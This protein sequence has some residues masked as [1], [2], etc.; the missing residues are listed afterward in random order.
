MKSW[1]SNFSVH[2]IIHALLLCASVSA[3]AALPRGHVFFQSDFEG[4]DDLNP[5]SGRKQVETG[6]QSA[7]SLCVENRGAS[8][9]G[10][11]ASLTLPAE[12]M[13]GHVVQVSA[14]VKAQDVSAKPNPWNG[15]KLMLVIQ[16]PEGPE[17][18]QAPLGVGSFDWQQAVYQ[19]RIPTNATKITL[20]A[21]MEQVTGKV[22]FDDVK[23]SVYRAMRTDVPAP[24]AGPMHKGHALPRLRGAMVA[25]NLT[26][27]SL[28]IFG[29]E[30][31]ANVIRWQLIRHGKPGAPSSLEDYDAWLDG[32][33]NKL[34]EVL[35]WCARAKVLVVVDL[36]SPPGGKSTTSGYVGSD[37]RLFTD[38]KVQDKFV[39][40]WERITKKYRG[41]P[42]IWG[43]DLANE[44]VED[45]VAEDC[46]DWQALAERA[47]K[48]VRA[49]DPDRTLIV[50]PSKWGGPDG[51]RDFL[52]INVSKVVYSVHMYLPGEFTH[53]GVHRK[54][55]PPVE[56][57]GQIGGKRW[58]KAE[59]ERALQPVVDFQKRFNVQIYMGEFSAIR[60]A[61]NQSAHR[62]LKD[63]IDIFEAHDWDWSYHAFREWSGWSVEHTEDPQNN[64][65]AA[66]PTERQKLL[67]SWYAK[68]QKP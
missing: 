3:L 62:Y 22:W 12:A 9:S 21:G 33:L 11:S 57:P 4:P 35:G 15:V 13:R 5:W 31:N 24:V 27:A 28:L 38:R 53:Q 65:P 42:W 37:D 14:W 1:R 32:Q 23:I 60:W 8:K 46:D 50:E 54:D 40:V 16:T 68:N 6:H 64:Q 44:P 25:P 19:A 41:N 7:R 61:P 29:Q 48:A 67:Q 10:A 30:W 66:Q 58:D 51:L 17:Y 34:D 56:Y 20:I 47:G 43:F 26:E 49:L 55:A 52:P 39:A 63:V 45:F 18:P 59:L 36:H 2:G